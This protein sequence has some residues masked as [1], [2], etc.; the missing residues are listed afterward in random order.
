MT[1]RERVLEVGGHVRVALA[2]ELAGEGA[3]V[4]LVGVV[5]EP[6]VEDFRELPVR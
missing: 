1:P 6:R 5:D 4:W 2:D 3:R